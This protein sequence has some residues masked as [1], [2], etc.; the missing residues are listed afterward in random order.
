VIKVAA[1]RAIAYAVLPWKTSRG[2]NM[3]KVP[4]SLRKGIYD[5][6]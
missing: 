6:L 5:R 4:N 3:S 2:R 1:V